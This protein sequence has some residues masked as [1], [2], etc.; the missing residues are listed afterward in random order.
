MKIR[1]KR[2]LAS[3]PDFRALTRCFSGYATAGVIADDGCNGRRS[4][5]AVAKPRFPQRRFARSRVPSANSLFL[6]VPHSPALSYFI[7]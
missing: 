2:W 3:G 1:L 6:A 5:K 4:L 7:Q